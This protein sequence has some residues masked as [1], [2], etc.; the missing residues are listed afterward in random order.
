MLSV[1]IIAPGHRHLHRHRS[2][3]GPSSL[4]LAILCLIL[5]T[6]TLDHLYF[7]FLFF[8]FR[9]HNSPLF[10]GS[11]QVLRPVVYYYSYIATASS[12]LSFPLLSFFYSLLASSILSLTSL[13]SPC[14]SF[15]FYLLYRKH[16]L[17]LPVA[18]RKAGPS[19]ARAVH[20]SR[21]IHDIILAVFCFFDIAIFTPHS[22][23]TASFITSVYYA[24][25]PRPLANI[26]QNDCYTAASESAAS[27]IVYAR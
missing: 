1:S 15:L 20:Q 8:D 24:T 3:G 22:I 4:L 10:L 12:L 7:F 19:T 21:L 17:H 25:D 14:I 5:H 18:C 2:P 11:S 26:T 23:A 16:S 13:G 9:I 27:L 6:S